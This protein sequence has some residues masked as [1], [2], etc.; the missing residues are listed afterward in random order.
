MDNSPSYLATPFKCAVVKLPCDSRDTVS[1]LYWSILVAVYYQV[2]SAQSIV[3]NVCKNSSYDTDD[4]DMIYC[5]AGF[6]CEAQFL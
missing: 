4:K 2:M 1:P 5:T 6:V 3:M